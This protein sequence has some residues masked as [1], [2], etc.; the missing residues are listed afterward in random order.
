VTFGDIAERARLSRPLVYFYFPDHRTLFLEA[1]MEARTRLLMI[2]K[3]GL[4]RG[5][6]TGGSGLAQIEGIAR[7]YS[8]FQVEEPDAFQLSSLCEVHAVTVGT[9]DALGQLIRSNEQSLKQCCMTALMRGVEDGSI[10]LLGDDLQKMTGVV[11]AWIH[12]MV[13]A[14]AANAVGSRNRK[15]NVVSSCLEVGL[16]LLCRALRSEI[17]RLE[18]DN[19]VD[20]RGGLGNSST[21]V[22]TY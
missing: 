7:A 17:P 1:V 11:W 3:D 19:Q 21:V 22:T 15:A 20:Q 6:E 4:E 16:Q 5:Q 2:F 10:E 14:Q 12:G 18:Q 8:Q 13:Q 9:A